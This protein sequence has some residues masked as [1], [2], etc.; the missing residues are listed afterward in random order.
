MMKTSKKGILAII[1]H[2]A[3][4]LSPYR[5]VEGVW[6][7]GVG[8]TKSAGPPNPKLVSQINLQEALHIFTDDLAKFERRVNDAVKVPIAQHEFDAMVSFDFN[9]GAIH[10]A[11]FVKTLNAGDRRL[12]AQQIM[13]WKKPPEIIGRR[14]KEQ[15]LFRSGR[16]PAVSKIKVYDEYPGKIRMTDVPEG[17]FVA[18]EGEPKAPAPEPSSPATDAGKD[19][20]SAGG[21]V[22]RILKAVLEALKG[23]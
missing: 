14:K 1:D 7:I 11:T 9:T 15:A 16:Y 6:T 20:A 18:Q 5:D 12:S 21:L 8:H 10:R 19:K 4:V 13:N 22:S 3:V 23:M 17:F 2:E